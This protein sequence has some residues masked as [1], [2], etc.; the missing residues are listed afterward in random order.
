V[1]TTRGEPI[2]GPIRLLFEVGTVA[3]MSDG[4]LLE[5]FLDRRRD[6]EAA[7]V[8]FAALV[9]RHGPMVLRACRARLG[10]EH[11]AQDAFQATFLILDPRS[12][13]RGDPQPRIGRELA[14]RG[15]PAGRLVRQEGGGRSSGQRT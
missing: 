14:A 3:G 15:R 4:Q 7:E 12:Q 11:D 13:G 8:A 2:L 5:R 9:E 10:D 6:E 1:E